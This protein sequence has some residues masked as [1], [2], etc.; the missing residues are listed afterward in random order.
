M[1]IDSIM[2]AS[3][4]LQAILSLMIGKHKKTVTPPTPP[5]PD[6]G[7]RGVGGDSCFFLFVIY[8]RARIYSK[9]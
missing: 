1:S 5:T 7:V 2:S 6:F 9:V 3:C 4:L 8:I